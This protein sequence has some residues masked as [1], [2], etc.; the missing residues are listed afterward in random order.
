MKN[1]QVFL[2]ISILILIL[3]GVIRFWNLDQRALI[4]WDEAYYFGVVKTYRIGFDWFIKNLAYGATTDSLKT[5]LLEEGIAVNPTAKHGFILILFMFS[6]IFGVNELLPLIVSVIF[7]I[8][9]IYLTGLIAS[10]IFN[11]KIGLLSMLLLTFSFFHV[12]Y[13]RSGYPTS[14]VI[15]FVCLGWFFY[16]SS[17]TC[18]NEKKYNLKKKTLLSGLSVGYAFTAH[19][20]TYWV[21]PLFLIF[22]LL[23]TFTNKITTQR[24]YFLGKK[25]IIFLTGFIF[26]LLFFEVGTRI[27]KIYV[28]SYAVLTNMPGS[29]FFV[30]SEDLFYQV[31]GRDTL[32]PISVFYF[33]LIVRW[34]GFL[35][36]SL[37][38]AS[39]V[40]G[41]FL[42]KKN[43]SFLLMSSLA[44]IFIPLIILSKSV[45]VA[46]N[47][48]VVLPATSI[49]IATLIYYI[50]CKLKSFNSYISI[51]TIS[52]FLVLVFVG[53]LVHL[54]PVFSI[55]SGMPKA[56]SFMQKN[57]SIKHI[58]SEFYLSRLYAGRMNIFDP[59]FGFSEQNIRDQVKNLYL[60]GYK[61]IL[62]AQT[63]HN[64]NQ[65][66]LELLK[67]KKPIFT[68]PHSVRIFSEEYTDDKIKKKVANL[69]DQI[70]VYSIEDLVINK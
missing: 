59:V 40:W 7:G 60:Q 55:Q 15:F 18:K 16:L 36:L 58:S 64:I 3:A 30:Y 6:F 22:L 66:L 14:V 62:I 1:K 56:I 41:I 34:E 68:T 29:N 67:D 49:L 17:L 28:E 38:I 43:H 70:E 33:D 31:L 44:M 2:V 63:K 65:R 52:L 69:S 26:P 51:I 46:R 19:Y 32:K 4:E 11:W 23:E 39:L 27:L 21:F 20:N 45:V 48:A 12:H 10:K 8:A 5:Q 61:F 57:G 37:I 53:G 42:I 35:V 25:N 47:I 54:Q 24:I 9:T 13:S 50:Y